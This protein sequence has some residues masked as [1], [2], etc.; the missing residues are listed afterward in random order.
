M[1]SGVEGL[2][3]QA[4][5]EKCACVILCIFSLQPKPTIVITCLSYSSNSPPKTVKKKVGQVKSVL[6]CH[7]F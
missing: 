4:G 3:G 6:P 1:V 5:N 7:V 2:N